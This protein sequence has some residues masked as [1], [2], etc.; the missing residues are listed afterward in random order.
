MRKYKNKNKEEE[1]EE[2]NSNSSRWKLR[3]NNRKIKI[4][5]KMIKKNSQKKKIETSRRKE[6]KR[7]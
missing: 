2:E 3:S 4:L 5:N 1:E 7:K 6:S